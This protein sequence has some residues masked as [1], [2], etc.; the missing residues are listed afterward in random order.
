[1][2]KRKYIESPEKMWELFTAYKKEVKDNP[3]FVYDFVGRDGTEVQKKLERPLTMEGFENFVM[4][5]TKITYPDL[6]EYFERKNESYADYFPISTRILKEIRQDQIEGGMIGQYNA[7][8]TARINALSETTK[9]E[10]IQ[11]IEVFKGIDLS[12]KEDDSTE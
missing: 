5:N 2:G 10:N 9:N 4:E 6:T 8:L 11:K 1:M 3:R 12:V 7:S